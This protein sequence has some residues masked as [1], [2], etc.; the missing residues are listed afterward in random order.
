MYDRSQL[1]MRAFFQVCD[2]TAKRETRSVTVRGM[3][4]I[5]DDEYG[6]I[7]FYCEDPN[8]DCRRS[9]V[10]VFSS[11]NGIVATFSY[12]WESR[13]YYLRWAG[14]SGYCED[15]AGVML[16]P[17]GQQSSYAPELLKVFEEMLQSH[18]EY[19]SRFP[20]H[21]REFKNAIGAR[22][23][24]TDRRIVR[25]KRKRALKLP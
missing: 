15:M 4:P 17:F 12:G 24:I 11:R 14:S 13:S 10:T 19:A 3:P 8:C 6:F 2:E 5:P 21:Y 23:P 7:D 20:R 9:I 18:P 16:E 25:A 1:N 22:N